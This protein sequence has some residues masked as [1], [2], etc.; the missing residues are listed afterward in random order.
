MVKAI[1]NARPYKS[2]NKAELRVKALLNKLFPN[3]YK[4]VGNG[5][6]ILGG[7]CPDFMNINGQKKLIELFGDYWH[8]N[9]NPEDRINYFK[10][11]GFDTLVLWEHELEDYNKIVSKIEEF[12]SV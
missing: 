12:N 5:E 10:R 8:R 4:F 6:F 9:D 1:L 2:P 11:F 3:E 7:K